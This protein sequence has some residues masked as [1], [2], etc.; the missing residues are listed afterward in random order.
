MI[1]LKSLRELS[2]EREICREDF[3]CLVNSMLLREDVIFVFG[4]NVKARE[5]LTEENN[6][7]FVKEMKVC[8]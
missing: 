8:S 2:Q 3:Y 4:Y 5:N 1:R 7:K 6:C